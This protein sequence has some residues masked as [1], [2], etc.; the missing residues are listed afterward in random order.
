M[1]QKNK[2]SLFGFKQERMLKL[3]SFAVRCL[4]QCTESKLDNLNNDLNNFLLIKNAI[5]L[6]ILTRKDKLL[7]LLDVV[8]HLTGD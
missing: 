3:I 4:Y 1:W 7:T 2:I 8:K 5:S 6:D